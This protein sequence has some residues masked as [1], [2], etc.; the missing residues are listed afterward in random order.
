MGKINTIA[1]N[2]LFSLDVDGW[3]YLKDDV[4]PKLVL[5]VEI[6]PKKATS[7][8]PEECR[9]KFTSAREW[10]PI[11]HQTAGLMCNHRYLW[12]TFLQVTAETQLKLIQLS[13]EY[14]Y[15]NL[16]FHSVC[17]SEIIGYRDRLKEIDSRLNC[18]R[19]YQDLEEAFYPVDLEGLPLLCTD[20]LPK[21]LDDLIEPVEGELSSDA[22][23]LERWERFMNERDRQQEWKLIILGENCD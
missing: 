1:D 14:Y 4:L 9:P 20:T 7:V 3:K 5:G 22:G 16:D 2:P 17:L 21:D 11:A 19:S 18:D 12:A 6:P 8:K 23:R 10:H 13:K 15:S